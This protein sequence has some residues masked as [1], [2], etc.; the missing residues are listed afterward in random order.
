MEWPDRMD[1]GVSASWDSL[2]SS[3]S[4]GTTSALSFVN[5]KNKPCKKSQGSLDRRRLRRL[6]YSSP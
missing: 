2:C 5:A 4:A 6:S 3:S 1:L